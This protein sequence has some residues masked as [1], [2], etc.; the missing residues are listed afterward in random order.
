MRPFESTDTAAPVTLR[1][2]AGL[3]TVDDAE[4]LV[5]WYDRNVRYG[6]AYYRLESRTDPDVVTVEDLGVAVLFVGQPRPLAARSLADE[7]L[8]ITGTPTGPLH[9]LDAAGR[10][11]LV[12]TIGTL[13]ARA[14]FRCALATKVLH[15]KRPAAIPVLDNQAIFATY[16]NDA[17]RPGDPWPSR[18]VPVSA[19]WAIA[20]GLDAVAG[21]LADPANKDSWERLEAAYPDLTRVE[22]FDKVW[23]AHAHRA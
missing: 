1:L 9:T 6:P 17:W 14:G 7:P 4:R 5:A 3:H 11:G 19:T 10:A 13:V 15:K 12:A 21:D 8:I 23:W 20:A 22:L 2:R 16:M 18:S